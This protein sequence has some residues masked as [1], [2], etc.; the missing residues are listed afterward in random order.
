MV[1]KVQFLS[2]KN[3]KPI[4]TSGFSYYIKKNKNMLTNLLERVQILGKIQRNLRF[5]D[6]VF[7]WI[8]SSQGKVESASQCTSFISQ[9]QS[10]LMNLMQYCCFEEVSLPYLFASL[11]VLF[12][13]C[14]LNIYQDCRGIWVE[15]S[16]LGNHFCF[17]ENL[18]YCALID[19]NPP[20]LLNRKENSYGSN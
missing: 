8:H 9:V 13:N 1:S 15:L 3:Y 4:T 5:S 18:L 14:N 17:I 11:P 7:W 12:V 20:L 19:Q 10:C 6:I 16:D 2:F